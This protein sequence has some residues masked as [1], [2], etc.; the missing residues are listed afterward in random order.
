MRN[1]LRIAEEG[2]AQY[3]AHRSHGA[4]GQ[5]TT[6]EVDGVMKLPDLRRHGPLLMLKMRGQHR[7]VR[8]DQSAA[9]AA[10]WGSGA[11]DSA[12]AAGATTSRRLSRARRQGPA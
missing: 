8:W 5:R 9:N 4:P 7:A 11:L 1:P 2:N 6:G 12:A 10:A 3:F